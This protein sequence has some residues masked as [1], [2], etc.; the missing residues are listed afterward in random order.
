[1]ETKKRGRPKKELIKE[2]AQD[3]AVK[4]KIQATLEMAGETYKS[5][6]ETI[7]DALSNFS[8]NWTNIKAKGIITVSDGAKQAE[9]LFYL[10]L[11]R[12][13]FA[14]RLRRKGFAWQLEELLKVALLKSDL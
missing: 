10:K 12:L 1:M 4:P 3:F 8:L 2:S 11:L 13:L 6:G 5:E 9:K 7:Y 14:N